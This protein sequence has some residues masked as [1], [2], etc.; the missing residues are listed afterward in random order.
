MSEPITILLVD[1]HRVVRMGIAAYFDTLPDF[2]VIGEAESGEEAVQLVQ[3]HVPN[4]VLMDLLMPGMDGVEATRRIF[5]HL[6]Y[7]GQRA[8][9]G[10]CWLTPSV[11]PTAVRYSARP[12]ANGCSRITS[13]PAGRRSACSHAWAARAIS[14]VWQKPPATTS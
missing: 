11:S 7:D 6:T 1:D 9:S 12:S 13:R 10:G 14:R 5:P 3:E 8:A 2:I 4:V